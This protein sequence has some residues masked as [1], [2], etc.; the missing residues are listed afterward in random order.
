MYKVFIVKVVLGI[1]ILILRLIVIG[2]DC[3]NA[4]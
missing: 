4:E 1:G 3:I 2:D